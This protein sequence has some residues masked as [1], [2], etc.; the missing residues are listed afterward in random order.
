MRKF[1]SLVYV[2]DSRGT[3]THINLGSTTPPVYVLAIEASALMFQWVARPTNTLST[4][5]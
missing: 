5:S 1:F 4:T 3:N 2:L